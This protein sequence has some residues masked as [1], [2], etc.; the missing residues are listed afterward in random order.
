MTIAICIK[1]GAEKFGALVPC[2]E[3]GFFPSDMVDRAKSTVLSDHHLEISELHR[4]GQEIRDGKEPQL[5]QELV[6]EYIALYEAD[7][8][9]QKSPSTDP[10]WITTALSFLGILMVPVGF[11]LLMVFGFN[12]AER[13]FGR[14]PASPISS[15]I[16]VEM[17][18]SVEEP[19][20]HVGQ[21]AA[22]FP[23]FVRIDSEDGNQLWIP[24]EQLTKIVLRQ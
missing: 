10:G 23:D 8:L 2:E 20:P 24:R 5:P 14:A 3:C 9:R 19:M 22:I 11:A 15:G 7:L 16:I 4:V 18:M 12:V 17:E 13:L 21:N 6:D 1:C